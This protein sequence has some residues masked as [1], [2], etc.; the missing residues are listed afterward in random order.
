MRRILFANTSSFE[1]ASRNGADI[2]LEALCRRLAAQSFE[3]VVLCGLRPGA[4]ASEHEPTAETPWR[5]LR[6]AG[7]ERALG[8]AIARFAPIA[9]V[10][11][12]AAAAAVARNPA[13]FALR[14]HVYF[15]SGFE[16]RSYPSRRQAPD[17][18][19]AACSPFL[20]RL[21]ET[22]FAAPVATIPPIVEPDTYRVARPQTGDAVL[23]VNP[24]AVKG[25]HIAAA[26][27]A[28]LPR[29]RFLFARSWPDT[30]AHPHV[31]VALPNVEWLPAVHDMRPIYAQARLVLVPSVWEES[32][33]RVVGEAQL[34]AI[35]A[36]ASDRGGL[37]ETV[38]PGGIVLPLAAPLEAWCEAV[39]SLFA[40]EAK[41]VALAQRAREH[42]T[43]PDL[44]PDA[45]VE[46]FL[47]WIG[48]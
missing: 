39:E 3:P 40:D 9:T 8:D 1:T 46:R 33:G 48:A 36:V 34:N 30:A 17:Y 21:A 18:R 4:P 7:S 35:P 24:V 32:Y 14:L 23:F 44:A 16:H 22:Y 11:R 42:A 25:V 45:I 43:R 47:G 41:Y 13:A 2:S 37:R 15:E 19:Y 5:L 26:V 31:E 6:A 28:R 29:R 20:A 12:G 38:G 27:A 10:L